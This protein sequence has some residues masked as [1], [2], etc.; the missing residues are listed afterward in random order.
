MVVNK[1]NLTA[2]AIFARIKG[3]KGEKAV[4][5]THEGFMQMDD[6]HRKLHWSHDYEQSRVTLDSFRADL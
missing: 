6:I 1:I 3:I 5:G 2:L 4:D